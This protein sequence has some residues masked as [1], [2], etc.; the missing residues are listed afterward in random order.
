LNDFSAHALQQGLCR[1]FCTATD[2]DLAEFVKDYLPRD[3]QAEPPLRRFPIDWTNKALVVSALTHPDSVADWG[4]FAAK[5]KRATRSGEHPLSLIEVSIVD[6]SDTAVTDA[7]N[8]SE[9]A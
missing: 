5:T 8:P 3:G 4:T 6:E 9:S 2:A 1:M 7:E